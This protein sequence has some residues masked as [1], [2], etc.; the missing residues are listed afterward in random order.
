MFVTLVVSSKRGRSMRGFRAYQSG[1]PGLYCSL[2]FLIT[3][4]FRFT[5]I[6]FREKKNSVSSR[7][8]RSLDIFRKNAI[9]HFYCCAEFTFDWLP[10][11][12]PQ[13][14]ACIPLK[15]SRSVCSSLKSSTGSFP[16]FTGVTFNRRPLSFHRVYSRLIRLG[17]R[18]PPFSCI[19]LPT[20][21]F[22]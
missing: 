17:T 21:C 3:F 6:L 5:E 12:G 20:W 8:T 2:N 15:D 19:R 1:V 22:L 4:C 10:L 9:Y 14:F 16:C 13:A 7:L 18:V 11:F